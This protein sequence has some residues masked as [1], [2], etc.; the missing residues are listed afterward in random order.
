MA[1]NLNVSVCIAD[2]PSTPTVQ[3]DEIPSREA[4]YRSIPTGQWIILVADIQGKRCMFARKFDGMEAEAQLLLVPSNDGPL[5]GAVRK[6]AHNLLTEAGTQSTPVDREV[7]AFNLLASHRQNPSAN[8][9]TARFAEL[10]Q[11]GDIELPTHP[12]GRRWARA[13]Y[14]KYYNGGTVGNMISRYEK[15][16]IT[17]PKWIAARFAHQ[18]LQTLQ[19]MYHVVKPAIVHRDLHQSN[20]LLHYPTPNNASSAPDFYLLDFGQARFGGDFLS[21]PT[22]NPNSPKELG[23]WDVNLFLVSFQRML[24]EE[25]R[26]SRN[27]PLGAF[28]QDLRALCDGYST[29]TVIPDLTPFIN[30]ARDL[31]TSFA[32]EAASV[33]ILRGP[34]PP[35]MPAIYTTR[36]EAAG[37]SLHGPFNIAR[38]TAASFELPESNALPGVFW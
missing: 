19:Y 16:A 6:V 7:R 38:R 15:E 21:D 22:E 4:I 24:S 2:E 20:I 10:T 14:W 3:P 25:D 5:S 11:N 12:G 31:E 33:G 28:R 18:V 13:T 30:R 32:A 36:D 23:T 1:V 26:T 8:G 17:V 34:N 9:L 29:A 35:I 37:A 27:N